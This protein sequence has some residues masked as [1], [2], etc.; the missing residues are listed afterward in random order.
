MGDQFLK[1]LTL[2]HVAKP[3]LIAPHSLTSRSLTHEP[4]HMGSYGPWQGVAVINRRI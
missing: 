2:N 4:A 1:T 3:L